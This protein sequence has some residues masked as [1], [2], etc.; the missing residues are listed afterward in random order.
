MTLLYHNIVIIDNK[1][2]SF[3]FLQWT[4]IPV[5]KVREVIRRI[6]ADS[7]VF[8]RHGG[9]SNHRI[10]KKEGVQSEIFISG[11]DGK[12]VFRGQLQDAGRKLGL[13]LR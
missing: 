10:C 13:P 11:K 3:I 9:R 8:V 2:I 5:V 12:K 4:G 6:E 1:I 7:C